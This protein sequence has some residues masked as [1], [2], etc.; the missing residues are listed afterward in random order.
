MESEPFSIPVKSKQQSIMESTVF[1]SYSNCTPGDVACLKSL[2]WQQIVD[3]QM[4]TGKKLFLLHPLDVFIPFT[5]TWDPSQA[6]L[7]L[8][9][10]DAFSQGKYSKVPTIMGHVS[11]DGRLFIYRAAPNF[12]TDAD[13]LALI[14]VVFGREAPS[15]LEHYP[16][17]PING[18]KRDFLSMF[19]TQYIFE[20]STRFASEQ[21]YK[22]NAK[23]SNNVYI[24]QF[25]HSMV[26]DVWGPL[27]PYC[28]GHVCHGAELPFVFNP[29]MEA[30]NVTFTP[31]EQILSNQMIAYWTNFAYTGDPNKGPSKTPMRWPSFTN[32]SRYMMEFMTPAND[33]YLDFLGSVC[34]YWD[35]MGY[36]YG[37]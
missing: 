24:F 6:E 18:D 4:A 10:I 36:R 1:Y 8:S 12:V 30:F 17:T 25:N 22:N 3:A 2:S 11:E 31:V 28:Y 29:P 16:P 27:Y 5:P 23:F 37:W 21:V 13:Y 33:V 14:G 7:P 20:C 34:N 32:S 19:A 9:P 35:G 26:D 15:V